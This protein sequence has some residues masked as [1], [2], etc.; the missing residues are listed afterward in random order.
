[1]SLKAEKM[2]K[3]LVALVTAITVSGAVAAPA[4]VAAN[5][6]LSTPPTLSSAA[7]RR[8]L[9]QA[10]EIGDKRGYRLC[11]AITDSSGNLLDFDRHDGAH[12]GCVEAAIAKAKSAASNGVDTQ[13]LLDLARDYNP[14]IGAIPG[15]IPAV[16]GVALLYQGKVIGGIGVAGGPNDKAEAD[17]AAELQSIVDGWLR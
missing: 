5:E 9:A 3:V 6:W 11:L 7:A 10:I 16:A 1:M 14:S 13:R 12:P 17:F 15:I 4:D 2:K 8:L